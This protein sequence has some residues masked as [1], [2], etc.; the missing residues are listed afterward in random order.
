MKLHF[1]GIHITSQRL[2]SIFSGGKGIAVT[3]FPFVFYSNKYIRMKQ[4]IQTH[5]II[6]IQ[7]QMECG[8]AG[9]LL[10]IAGVIS[11]N[12]VLL[13]LPA[14]FLYYIIYAVMYLVNLIKHNDSYKAY[15]NIA[16][17]KE[18]YKNENQAEYP[19]FRKPFAWLKEL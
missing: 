15:E 9:V 16:F 11:L 18:S 1:K 10:F 4:S 19:V 13:C 3:V 2:T 6:H 14:V 17:E 7:Q 12:Q 8:L 5:E